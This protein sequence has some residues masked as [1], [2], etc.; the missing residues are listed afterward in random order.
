VNAVLKFDLRNK[1]FDPSF[2]WDTRNSIIP[3]TT[4]AI[5]LAIEAIHLAIKIYKNPD[6]VKEG[7]LKVKVDILEAFTKNVL[8]TG[9]KMIS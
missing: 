9:Q 4:L 8:C 6:C 2:V 3:I 7:L 5:P 1:A